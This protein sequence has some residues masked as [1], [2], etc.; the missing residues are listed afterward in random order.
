MDTF[1]NMLSERHFGSPGLLCLYTGWGFIEGVLDYF[2]V[3]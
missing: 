3:L 1:G 2:G